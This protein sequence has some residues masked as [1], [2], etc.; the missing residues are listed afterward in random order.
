VAVGD[1]DDELGI[2]DTSWLTDADWAEINKLRR[3]Y[4][5]DGGSGLWKALD[6]LSDDPVRYF[7][8]VAALFPAKV[9]NGM[10]DH[11]AKIGVTEEDLKER[12]EK[13]QPKKH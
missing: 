6:R 5:A 11:M 12:I 3:I 9:L 8:L 2:Q 13:L 4:A 10:K 1:R 7:R